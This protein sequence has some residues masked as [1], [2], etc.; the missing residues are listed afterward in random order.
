MVPNIGWGRGRGKAPLG[1]IYL[2]QRTFVP[3]VRGEGEREGRAPPDGHTY[4][5]E[6]FCNFVSPLCW[7]WLSLGWWNDCGGEFI[8]N[9]ELKCPAAL[10]PRCRQLVLAQIPV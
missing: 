3:T 2:P 7:G 1:G 5:K 6:E 4:P 8:V 9:R 10:Y